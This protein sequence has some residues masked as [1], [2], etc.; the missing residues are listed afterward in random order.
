MVN[1]KYKLYKSDKIKRIESLNLTA[2]IIWN[3]VTALQKRYYRI[4]GGYISTNKMQKHIAKIRKKNFFWKKLNSQSVQ[5]ICQRHDQ[6]Y[7]EFFKYCKTR[8]GSKRR[9]HQLLNLS[10]SLKVLYLKIQAG[11]LKII[12]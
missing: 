2:C 5:E 9:D 11:N 12:N 8:K 3:H 1:L 7:Q 10:I 6:S 4:Y